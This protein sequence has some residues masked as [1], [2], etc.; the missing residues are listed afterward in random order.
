MATGDGWIRTEREGDRLLLTAGG[1]WQISALADIDTKLRELSPGSLRQARIDLSGIEALDSTGA[2][3]LHRTLKQ[4]RASGLA[5]EFAGVGPAHGEM[6]ALIERDDVEQTL[7]R[8]EMPPITAMVQRVG[9]AT[10]AVRDEA[11]DLLNFLGA[12]TLTTVRSVA[13]PRRLRLI[14]LA[15]HVERVGLDALPIVGLLSFLIG[16]VLAYQGADQL[17]RFG[18]EIFTV[19]LLG[20]S[21]LREMAVLLTAIVIAGRS[22][23]AFTAEIGTM[24]VNEEVDALR[25]IGLDPV[26]VLVLPRILALVIALPLLTVFADLMG[27]VGGALMSF[28]VLDISLVQFA[29]RFKTVIPMWSFWIGMIKA[30][31]FGLAIG[32]VGCREGLGVSGS[33]ES[34]GRQT[35]KSVVVSIFLVIIID[36][37]FSILFSLVGV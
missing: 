2:W 20:V 13:R 5:A 10:Y 37:I 34:V 26:E 7:E 29:E 3:I 21:I 12:T 28:I 19:D 17:R 36:A 24:Q 1:R 8:D 32:L 18:A 11:A 22:G 31:V 25:T 14:S 15:S 6:L 30:P 23:S 27:L 9:Q 33:A 16:I 35:T 4:L